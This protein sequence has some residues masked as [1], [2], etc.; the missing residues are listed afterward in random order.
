MP[1]YNLTQNE[2]RVIVTWLFEPNGYLDFASRSSDGQ[3]A[4]QALS[5]DSGLDV[6]QWIRD[7]AQTNPGDSNEV[8]MVW[9]IRV[10]D[11][12]NIPVPQRPPESVSWAAIL[13]GWGDTIA[14]GFARASLISRNASSIEIFNEDGSLDGTI[15]AGAH[16]THQQQIISKVTGVLI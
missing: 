2:M 1:S 7:N 8:A 11:Q 9:W 14:T 3:T 12:V 4:R 6:T 10:N 13:Q 5:A 15:A 16:L